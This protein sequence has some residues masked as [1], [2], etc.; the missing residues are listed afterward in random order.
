MSSLISNL[1]YPECPRWHEGCLWF[2]DQHAGYVYQINRNGE[3]LDSF[4]VAGGPAGL[5][6]LPDGD[7]IVV[8]MSE[9]RLYRRRQR[10]LLKLVAELGDIHPGDSNDLVVDA[11]GNAYIGNIG[12]NFDAG[13]PMVTTNLAM[14]RPDGTSMIAARN[15][16]VP[17]GSVI[18]ADGHHLI[19]AE[20]WAHRLTV[21][22]ILPDGSLTDRRVWAEL[23]EHVPDGICLDAEGA[24]WFASPFANGVYRV[25]EGGEICEQI[26]IKAGRPYAC[27]LGGEKGTDLFVCIAPDHDRAVTLARREGRIDVYAVSVC[28]AGQP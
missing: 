6:W 24:I 3:V 21:F 5:G 20:S 2:S 17:N 16:M 15:L 23:A 27:M 1:A 28:R 18:T 10:S 7:L 8:S 12:F 9:K 26:P 22:R 11:T 14:V 4:S 25:K 19:I 13:D